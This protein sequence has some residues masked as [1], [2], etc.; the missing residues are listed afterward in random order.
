MQ[1]SFGLEQSGFG[2]NGLVLVQEERCHH[3]AGSRRNFQSIVM[4]SVVRK[5]SHDAMRYSVC[6]PKSFEDD[7]GQIWQLFEFGEHGTIVSVWHD[8]LQLFKQLHSDAGVRHDMICRAFKEM[9]PGCVWPCRHALVTSFGILIKRVFGVTNV[10]SD[11]A[12]IKLNAS[13]RRRSRLFSGSGRLLSSNAWKTV[14]CP[15]PSWELSFPDRMSSTC[16]ERRCNPAQS[17]LL[18][19]STRRREDAPRGQGT[20]MSSTYFSLVKHFGHCS[21]NEP[22]ETILPQ[23]NTWKSNLS[24]NHLK[25]RQRI[26]CTDNPWE[27][28]SLDTINQ[29]SYPKHDPIEPTSKLISRKTWRSSDDRW[30]KSGMSTELYDFEKQYSP[31]MSTVSA[32]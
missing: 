13:S 3:D 11:P 17:R 20:W 19:P 28:K 2:E 31:I 18:S 16:F 27:V 9:R 30:L 29:L 1:P 15:D 21:R 14:T 7:G 8:G 5:S 25:Y 10:V 23:L 32:A 26:Q 4:K 12:V 24:R 6:D 22:H